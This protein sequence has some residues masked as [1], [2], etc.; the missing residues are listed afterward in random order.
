A[1]LDDRDDSGGERELG[2]VGKRE[3]RV[4]REYGAAEVVLELPGLF[5]RDLHR[6]DAAL[7]TGPDPDR[8]Q[9]LRDHDRV[10][11]DVLAHAPRE[12]EVAPLLFRGL[13][14]D[15]PHRLA[16]LDVP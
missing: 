10:R 11:A 12:Q 3:E 6:V 2:P 7:L 1:G 5:E 13:A 14:A 16:I 15:D 9:S 4:G 8:L